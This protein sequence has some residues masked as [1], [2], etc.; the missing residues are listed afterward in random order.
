MRL[1][2]AAATEAEL[3]EALS[4]VSIYIIGGLE[5]VTDAV[6]AS[7][8]TLEAIIF[9]GVDY[10]KFIPAAEAARQKGIKLL[11]A[12]GANAVAVAEF[13]V[14]VAIV[15]QRDLFGISRTGSKKFQTTKSIQGSTVGVIGA[16][17][18]AQAIICGIVP[19]QPA[20]IVYS[21]RSK[22]D[23]AHKYIS[24]EDLV[25]MSDIIFLTLPMKAGLT[26]SGDMISKIKNGCLIVSVSP[27][28][29][30]D[31]NA[32]LPRLEKGELRCAVDWPAPTAAFD[33]LPL[34]VWFHVNS[35]SAYNTA[36]AIQRVSNSV[37]KTAINLL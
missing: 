23:I 11:N 2:K 35:H 31:F 15:M 37:T 24:L 28:G 6:I 21:N 14:G 1:E 33:Q 3:I 20:E 34:D 27:M 4:G 25:S 36:S 5:Q 9:C 32:L 26:L 18:I 8:D 13:A 29:L 30:I 10:D 12:P 16:G 22:K 7:T 17:H 19:F